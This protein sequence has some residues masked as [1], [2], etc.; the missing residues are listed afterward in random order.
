MRSLEHYAH[1]GYHDAPSDFVRGIVDLS[2]PILRGDSA[3]A[4]LT[5]PFVHCRPL[6]VEMAQAL[7]FVRAAARQ[8]SAEMV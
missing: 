6:L 5:I 7:E 1:R 4:V 8:I 3:I 2:A